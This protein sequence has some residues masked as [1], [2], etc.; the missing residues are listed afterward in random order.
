[1]VMNTFNPFEQLRLPLELLMAA[2]EEPQFDSIMS[3]F[4]K[5]TGNELQQQCQRGGLL[6]AE[7]FGRN[8]PWLWTLRFATRGL[9]RE[10]DGEVHVVEQHVVAVRFLPDYLRRVN[11]FETVAMIEPR[12]PT[13]F[14]PNVSP[15]GAAVCV[16]I[17]PGESLTEIALS[18]HALIS[19]RLK[20]LDERDALNKDACAYWREHVTEP[21]DDRPLF[22]APR[23]L[24]IQIT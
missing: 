9:V 10:A 23:R 8:A 5:Q 4:V 24:A 20:T 14:H 13:A 17:F 18:L 21:F 2:G 12:Q 16:E 3:G 6:R 19:G 11:R 7:A 22:G 15:D 1:M